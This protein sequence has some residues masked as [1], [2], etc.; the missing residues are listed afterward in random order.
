MTREEKTAV[1]EELREKFNETPNFYVCDASGMTVEQTN[2]FRRM[3][4]ERGIEYRVIKNTLIKKAL[5]TNGVDYTE[6][7]QGV[8]KGF[9]GVLFAPE[10]F[11]APASLLK[12]YYKKSN[13]TSPVLKGATIDASFFIGADQLDALTKLKNKNELIGEVIGLLQSPA[14]NVISALKGQ[15]SKIAGILKTLAER[16][17]A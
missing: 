2:N 5:E 17:A 16:E 1:I 14:Q 3:C 10:N 9:S 11:K 13:S 7:N 4:Y 12:D 15:G 6:F 8:L